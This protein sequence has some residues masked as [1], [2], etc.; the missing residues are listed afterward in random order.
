MKKP[1]GLAPQWVGGHA[2]GEF[3][4]SIH[5]DKYLKII[6]CVIIS[7]ALSTENLTYSYWYIT[8]ETIYAARIMLKSRLP[9]YVILF[10][11]IMQLD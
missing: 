3:N 4:M 1:Q 9:S 7:T 10:R 8:D 11:V 2:T 6:R 5:S